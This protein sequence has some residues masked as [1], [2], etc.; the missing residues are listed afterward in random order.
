[1]AFGGENAES[2]YD[3]G[4]TLAMRGDVR[5]AIDHF[6]SAI[7]MDN[8]MAPAYHQ[9]AKCYHRVGDYDKAIQLL[10]QVVNQRKDAAAARLDLGYALIQ[11]GH[12]R[13][14]RAEFEQVVAME[15]SK[16]RGPLGLAE[17]SFQEGDWPGAVQHAQDAVSLG[18]SGFAALFLLGR[19]AKLSGN[20]TLSAGSLEKADKLAEKSV[21]SNPQG[22]EGYFLRGEVHFAMDRFGDALE[23]YRLAQEKADR[24]RVYTAYGHNFTTTDI[25]CKQ[26]LCFQR[27]GQNSRA[28]D[29]GKDVLAIDPNHRLGKALSELED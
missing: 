10:R 28:R 2:Y 26:G 6:T 27:L 1:M 13:E 23:H 19:A 7:R 14:A 22:P 18:G 12:T 29:L 16:G 11:A 25:L 17:V 20:K 5:S 8:A 24:D 21:E 15:P 4:V 3:E 9:L